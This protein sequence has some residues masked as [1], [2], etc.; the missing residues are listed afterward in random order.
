MSFAVVGY[1]A[2][3]LIGLVV[4]YLIPRK[5][6]WIWLLMLSYIYY[7]TF[8]IRTSLYMVSTTL[9]IYFGGLALNKV[10]DNGNTYLKENKEQLTKE[11]KKAYKERLKKRKRLVLTAIILLC[12]GQLAVVKYSGFAL[13]NINGIMSLFGSKKQFDVVQFVLPLGIS[14]FTFQSVSYIVDVYQG[15]YVCQKNPFKLALFVSFFPQLLQGPIGRYDRLSGQLYEGNKFDLKNVEFGLQRIIWGFGKKVVLADRAAVVVN[16]VFGNYDNY[17]G[18]FNVV[19]VLMYSVQLY[20]DFSGGIDIVIGTAQMFGIRMDENFRQPY[21]SKSI[22]EFWRRWHITLGAWMKDYIF[23]PMS[24][25][26]G[27]NKFSK[28]GRKHIGNFVGRTLPICFVDIV[29]F[30]IVGIWHG[31]SWKYIVY[32][33]YNGFIL[34]FSSLMEPVYKK[35]AQKCHIN[36]NSRGWKVWQ[37]LRTF[38]LVNIG[39]YFDMAGSFKDALVMM[40]YT[41]VG[42]SPSLLFD[43]SLLRLGIGVRDYWIILIGCIVIFVI[44]LL[45]EKG[46]SIRESIAKKNIVIRWGIWYVFILLII[47]FGYTGGVQAFLYANF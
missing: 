16:E 1:F 20:M 28:W 26:K 31:A 27:M 19:A 24:L 11:E 23:Y 37:M 35:M 17:G 34:A 13:E 36:T 32:G 30:F 9:F 8:N 47:I 15:K 3:L 33:L 22:G 29:I 2:F 45:K 6:S 25:S 12:F 7:F 43:G 18:L 44:S 41:V 4:Y 46:V 38:I 40:K 42:F 21:F 10:I 39:W 5:F 14:F